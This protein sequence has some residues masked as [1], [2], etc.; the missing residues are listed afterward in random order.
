M[1]DNDLY[2]KQ[3]FHERIEIM[4][5][6]ASDTEKISNLHIIIQYQLDKPGDIIGYIYGT[7][8]EAQRLDDFFKNNNSYKLR[9]VNKSFGYEVSS[10][11]VF[12]ESFSKQKGL[13]NSTYKIGK[14]ILNDIRNEKII[15]FSERKERQLTFFLAGPANTWGMYWTHSKSYTGDVELDVK[16]SQIDL[17]K[18]LP[19]EIEL[20]PWY[21]HDN[22]HGK[23]KY[24]V[25]TFVYAYSLKTNRHCKEYSDDN[26]IQEG[27]QTVDKLVSLSSLVTGSRVVWYG[28][29]IV[30]NN[31][32]LKYYRLTPDVREDF[33]KDYL[34]LIVNGIKS[35][36][37]LSNSYN[38][39]CDKP[40]IM[41]VLDRKSTRLNSSHTDI[42]RMPSSA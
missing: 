10:N 41:E 4:G 13:E 9:A 17:N 3:L 39:L 33:D 6:I 18:N 8:E 32:Y 42:S 25:E 29:S 5:D 27:I 16:G 28:Y 19:F 37:F 15:E 30:T 14:F 23:K 22:S 20:I 31:S 7:Y 38:L 34:S 24:D 12:I 1:D 36:E 40:K 35:R 11:Q 21:F 26:F 2:P